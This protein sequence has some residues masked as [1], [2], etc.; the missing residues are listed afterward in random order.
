MGL[1]IRDH[2][3]TVNDVEPMRLGRFMEYV[4]IFADLAKVSP[5]NPQ[6]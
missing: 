1:L 2:G 4:D 3:L 6:G 5:K